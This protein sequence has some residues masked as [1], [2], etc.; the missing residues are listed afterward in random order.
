MTFSRHDYSKSEG[1]NDFVGM[2]CKDMSLEE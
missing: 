1:Q 2:G